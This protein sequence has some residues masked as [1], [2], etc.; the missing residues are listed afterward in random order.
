MRRYARDFSLAQAPEWV[1]TLL[2]ALDLNRVMVAAHSMGGVIAAMFAARWPDKVK[3]L[4]LAA[5]AIAPPQRSILAFG[6]P[7]LRETASVHPTFLPTLAGDAARSGLRTLW[8]VGRELLNADVD[9]QLTRID[10]PCLLLWGERDSLVPAKLS[11][12]LQSKIRGSELHIIRRAGHILMYDRPDEF[13]QYVLTF[14]AR[15]IEQR[16]ATV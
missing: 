15:P 11:R 4:V 1:S 14:L 16:S 13:N 2:T 6:L 7:L 10:C 12:V 8:R 5:P 9:E 3:K